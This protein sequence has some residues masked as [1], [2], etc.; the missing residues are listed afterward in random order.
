MFFEIQTA[1]PSA[2]DE[3]FFRICSYH[4]LLSCLPHLI[5]GEK[6]PELSDLGVC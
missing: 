1:F 4:K 2:A 3:S 6:G 5:H